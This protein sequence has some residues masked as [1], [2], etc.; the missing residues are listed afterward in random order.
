VLSMLLI[1]FPFEEKG[2]GWKVNEWKGWDEI[3][4]DSLTR[5][6]SSLSEMI[7][8]FITIIVWVIDSP[9]VLG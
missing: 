4:V 5:V 6:V 2:K 7:A 3:L 8:A 1:N 9:R